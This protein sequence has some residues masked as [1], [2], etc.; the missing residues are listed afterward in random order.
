MGMLDIRPGIYVLLFFLTAF[1]VS[2]VLWPMAI[3][4]SRKT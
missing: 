4:K 3:E 1:G 2:W